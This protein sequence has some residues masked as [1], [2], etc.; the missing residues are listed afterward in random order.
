MNLSPRKTFL[1]NADRARAHRD[2]VVNNNFRAACEA[3][4]LEQI[5]T[6]SEII[7]PE[8]AAAEYQQIVG[9]RNFVRHL[10]NLAEAPPVPIKPPP[11]NL[12]RNT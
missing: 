1:E 5:M 2:L 8:Q 6:M 4:L 7:H 12:N 11:L 10:L 3:A 9:A